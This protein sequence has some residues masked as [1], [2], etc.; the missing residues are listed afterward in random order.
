MT[1]T[2]LATTFDVFIQALLGVV[3]FLALV[4][5]WWTEDNRRPLKVALM[6]GSKQ[7]GGFALAREATAAARARPRDPRRSHATACPAQTSSTCTSRWR[8][9][10]AR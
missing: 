7:G 3:S 1:C 9:C 8:A 4:A 6:D 2:I 5:K 10:P